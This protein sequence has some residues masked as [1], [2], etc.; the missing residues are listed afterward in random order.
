MYLW[1]SLPYISHP[2]QKTLCRL[3]LSRGELE[4]Q[5]LFILFLRTQPTAMKDIFVQVARKSHSHFHIL[6]FSHTTTSIEKIKWRAEALSN[7]GRLPKRRGYPANSIPHSQSERGGA[8][9][10]NRC[11]SVANNSVPKSRSSQQRSF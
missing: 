9:Y 8:H 3:L 4:K 7:H 11:Q 5:Y 2:A 6:F 1:Y 10:F